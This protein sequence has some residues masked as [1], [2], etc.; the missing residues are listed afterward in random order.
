MKETRQKKK[1]DKESRQGNNEKGAKKT[2]KGKTENN[3]EIY[4][5]RGKINK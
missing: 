3:T 2:Q 5:R 4:R 1:T